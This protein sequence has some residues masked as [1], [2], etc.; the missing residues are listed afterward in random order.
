VG[1]C[2]RTGNIS[3][4]FTAILAYVDGIDVAPERWRQAPAVVTPVVTENAIVRGGRTMMY[5]T[6]WRQ[7]TPSIWSEFDRLFTGMPDARL[8]YSWTPVVD[9]RETEDALVLSAELPGLDS[10]NVA[11][12]VEDNVLTI[13]G[14]KKQEF[15]ETREDGQFHIVERHY[16]RFE[17]SF[18][19]P[20]TVNADKIDAR[21]TNGVLT[22][23]LPKVEAAR[24]RKI[25]VKVK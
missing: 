25:E 2:C 6:L 1:P 5:P 24:P 20:E 13:S 4:I 21:F 14:E 18:R 7:R 16:G 22:I 19:L 12:S 9:V 11:V 3:T 23:S 17:R 15:D 8:A 10:K